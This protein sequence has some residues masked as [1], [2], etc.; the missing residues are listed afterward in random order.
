MLLEINRA[1]FEFY[2]RTPIVDRKQLMISYEFHLLNKRRKILVNH[3]MTPLRL[4][5][6]GSV[7]LAVCVVSFSSYKDTGHIEMRQAGLS[8]Y[9]RYSLEHHKWEHVNGLK[10]SDREKDMLL[11]SARGYKIHE[12]AE[13][14]CYSVDAVKFHRQQIFNLLKANNITE[15][16]E[17]ASKYKL[18]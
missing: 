1:G 2:A 9:W 4:A 12:I 6:D 17:I 7:W 3:K 8:D 13:R 15:A 11:L 18:F 16:L 5:R 10:F 14:L